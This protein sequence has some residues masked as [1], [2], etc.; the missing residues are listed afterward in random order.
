VC[1]LRALH[2][3]VIVAIAAGIVFSINYYVPA[4]KAQY[5]PEC[6]THWCSEVEEH[7]RIVYG[8]DCLNSCC[9]ITACGVVS[10][11]CSNQEIGT[12]DIYTCAGGPVCGDNK[13][14][15]GEICD[16]DDLNEQNC[17]SLG[18]GGGN[19]GCDSDCHGFDFSGCTAPH[20][21]CIP[22]GDCQSDNGCVSTPGD[23]WSWNN[24]CAA[25]YGPSPGSVSGSGPYACTNPGN[26]CTGNWLTSQ[27]C[28][29]TCVRVNGCNYDGVCDTQWGE[30]YSNCPYD[31]CIPLAICGNNET[32]SGETCDGTDLND[33]TC[34]SQ[35]YAGGTLACAANCGSFVTSSCT[36]CGN[37]VIDSGEQCDGGA[38]G[39]SCAS[40]PGSYT[41]GTLACTGP[42]IGIGNPYIQ[43][44]GAIGKPRVA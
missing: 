10:T 27:D 5:F 20:G 7:D 24:H 22:T 14:E 18:Y 44:I 26:G 25:G 11:C 2:F 29:C 41:G 31:N 6:I 28:Y 19:L 16:G 33:Q 12:Y 38:L 37:G 30:A 35:G 13:R 21:Y 15:G 9:G 39:G 36:M 43:S 8:T 42:C 23:I 4:A 32:E 40:V 3:A 17:Q 1:N 34:Q